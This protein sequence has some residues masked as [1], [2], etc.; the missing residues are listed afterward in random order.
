MR[1]L[2]AIY[3]AKTFS[4]SARQENSDMW[5]KNLGLLA[6]KGGDPKRALND[7]GEG[8]T[9][10]MRILPVSGDAAM[11]LDMTTYRAGDNTAVSATPQTS[12]AKRP[13]PTPSQTL[14]CENKKIKAHYSLWDVPDS[15]S[16]KMAAVRRKPKRIRKWHVTQ[17]HFHRT[18]SRSRRD[19]TTPGH[20]HGSQGS[21]RPS[22]SGFPRGGASH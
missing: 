17:T 19:G 13:F 7:G 16:P 18:S 2:W 21:P 4:C 12:R 8:V 1:D 5:T 3:I 20:P 14:P 15:E 9:Y 22:S 11:Q 10:K 6:G